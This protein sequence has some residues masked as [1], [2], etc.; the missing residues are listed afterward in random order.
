MMTI[1]N[2]HPITLQNIKDPE[3]PASLMPKHF[4]TYESNV[5]VTP[6]SHFNREGIYNRKRWR[7]L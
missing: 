7:R 4:L 2:G 6:P 5:V 1:I 3:S